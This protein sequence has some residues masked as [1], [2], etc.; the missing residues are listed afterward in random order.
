[1]HH[2]LTP[3][4]LTCIPD[5]LSAYQATKFHQSVGTL[6]LKCPRWTLASSSSKIL[7]FMCRLTYLITLWFFYLILGFIFNSHLPL[8]PHIQLVLKSHCIDLQILSQICPLLFCS[9]ARGVVSCWDHWNRFQ[10]LF[11]SSQLPPFYPSQRFYPVLA[12]RMDLTLERRYH[13]FLAKYPGIHQQVPF[14]FCPIF[15]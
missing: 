9:T 14:A 3:S 5:P 2:E 8:K 12:S 1:M 11:P 7:L 15:H 13:W 4:N 10:V 6:H